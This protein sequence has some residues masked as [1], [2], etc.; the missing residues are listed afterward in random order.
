MCDYIVVKILGSNV[1]TLPTSI[2]IRHVNQNSE[3]LMNDVRREET[4]VPDKVRCF[5]LHFLWMSSLTLLR[6]QT[7]VFRNQLQYK[8]FKPSFISFRNI[9]CTNIKPAFSRN[10]YNIKNTYRNLFTPVR[11]FHFSKRLRNE[12]PTNGAKYINLCS[13]LPLCII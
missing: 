7:F 2:K 11:G 6:R 1:L 9:Q 13:Y 10:F 4:Q 5:Y 12:T 8:T 3:K